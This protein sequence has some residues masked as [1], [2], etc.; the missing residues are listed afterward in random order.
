MKPAVTTTQKKVVKAEPKNI[1]E[2]PQEI[3]EESLEV[4]KAVEK[5]VDKAVESDRARTWLMILGVASVVTVATV[6]TVYL[7]RRRKSQLAFED[8]ES[9]ESVEHYKSSFKQY[10][11]LA[12]NTFSAV[13]GTVKNFFSD[14]AQAQTPFVNARVASSSPYMNPDASDSE[15][16]FTEEG[17]AVL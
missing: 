14:K 1:Q 3:E 4:K 5:A 7:Y 10:W 15:L 16:V 8:D 12:K 11:S 17:E 6:G 9:Y 2:A 13:S